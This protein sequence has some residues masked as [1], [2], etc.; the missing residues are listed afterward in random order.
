MIEQYA[1][2]L[3]LYP[4][5]SYLFLGIVFLCIGSFLNVVIMRLPLMLHKQQE[6]ISQITLKLPVNKDQQFVN[7]ITPRSNCVYCKATIST[8]QNIPV[9]SFIF[10]RG[11]CANCS[12]LIS[13]IYPLVEFLCLALSICAVY[14]L[15]FGWHLI[16][17][18]GFIWIV[19]CLIFID[20]RTQLLPDSLTLSLLWLGLLANINGLYTPLPQAVIGAIVAY[21]SL[22]I[23]INIYYLLTGKIGMGGGDFKLFAGLGAW[24]GVTSLPYILVTASIPGI[25]FGGGYLL[26][27]GKSRNTP[28]P[29]GPFLGLAGLVF[30]FAAE[31]G[32]KYGN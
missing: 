9:L 25:I 29:F 24:F 27:S 32:L 23:F 17:V 30:I 1:E 22:W 20:L 31:S 13:F 16:Y 21:L 6:R 2:F 3:S 18:L 26:I 28:I 4:L 12:H 11:R 14:F 5:T 10:L 19:L 8:W 7:L 15:G